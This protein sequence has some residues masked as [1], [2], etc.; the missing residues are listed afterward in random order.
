M[1]LGGRAGGPEDG[2]SR[3][4]APA[5]PS[6]LFK[7]RPPSPPTGLSRSSESAGLTSAADRLGKPDGPPPRFPGYSG[8]KST[9]ERLRDTR[10]LFD[11]ADSPCAKILSMTGVLG[12]ATPALPSFRDI[13]LLLLFLKEVS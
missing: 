13:A 11:Q 2:C 1:E 12:A 9:Y 3:P 7:S 6:G 5:R 8:P 4:Q 10:E